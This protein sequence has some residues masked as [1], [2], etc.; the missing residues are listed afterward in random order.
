MTS[1]PA[2]RCREV[3]RL[4]ALGLKCRAIGKELGVTKSAIIGIIHRMKHGQAII[5]WVTP[6]EPIP[7]LHAEPPPPEPGT[8]CTR[9]GCRGPRQRV[10][11]LG[12]CAE[13]IR[14]DLQSAKEGKPKLVGTGDTA[15]GFEVA[16]GRGR[17]G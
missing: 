11:R 2:E 10:D 6:P 1:W 8:T 16:E 9:A 5:E 3:K 14:K 12:R 13:C 17:N 7:T 15:R 4:A